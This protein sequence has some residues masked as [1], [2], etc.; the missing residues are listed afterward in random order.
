MEDDDVKVSNCSICIYEMVSHETFSLLTVAQR[1]RY[2]IK[3]GYIGGR[4][5]CVKCLAPKRRSS[6]D[7]TKRSLPSDINP[8]QENAIR[9]LENF[10]D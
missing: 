5:C 3:G 8:W 9:D 4:P 6:K 2:L 7:Y 10:N 1:K